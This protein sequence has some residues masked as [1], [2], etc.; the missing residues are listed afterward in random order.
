MGN[1]PV[2][3]PRDG[4]GFRAELKIGD[5]I[6]LVLIATHRPGV[7]TPTRR[8]QGAVPESRMDD[9]RVGTLLSFEIGAR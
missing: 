5:D 3:F 1:T 7:G 8:P 6:H 4:Q 9:D 2:V